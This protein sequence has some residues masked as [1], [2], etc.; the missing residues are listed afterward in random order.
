MF[1]KL[2]TLL[3]PKTR[4]LN[5]EVFYDDEKDSIIGSEAQKVILDQQLT[6][7][8]CNDGDDDN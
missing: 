5:E 1:S 8:T 7:K 6:F 2:N 3:S 4:S